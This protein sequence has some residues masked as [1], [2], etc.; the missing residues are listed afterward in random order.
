MQKE[1]L[2]NKTK[3]ENYCT[4]LLQEAGNYWPF[5]SSEGI[6]YGASPGRIDLHNWN[7]HYQYSFDSRKDKNM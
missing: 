5:V 6:L 2:F 7:P 4:L 3:I 1:L